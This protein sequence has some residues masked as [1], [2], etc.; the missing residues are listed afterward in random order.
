MHFC[1][2]PFVMVY[3]AFAELFPDADCECQW[4]TDLQD[5]ESQPVC[6]MTFFPDDGG[7]PTVYVSADIP[8]KHAVEILAHELAHVAVGAG[9]EHGPQWQDAF[10]RIHARYMDMLGT[11]D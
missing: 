8:V 1:N 7:M 6:G 4:A 10:R 9:C 11:E 5:E 3:A 2:D